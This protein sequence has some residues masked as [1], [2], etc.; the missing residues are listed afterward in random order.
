MF[1]IIIPTYNR[2]AFISKAID[3]VLSQRYSNWELIV[4][5]DASTDNTSELLLHYID[6]RIHVITNEINKERSASRNRGIALAKGEYIC[7]LDSDDYFLPQHLESIALSIEQ[8]NNKVALFYTGVQKY[9]I[10]K[11]TYEILARI[12]FNN[13]VETVIGCNILPSSVAIHYSI[14]K[15]FQFDE[16][17]HINEDVYLF[18]LI[19][20]SYP[21]VY[22]SDLSVVWV[23][24]GNNTIDQQSECF[25]P[26][27]IALQ[28][29]TQHPV[30]SPH[31]TTP[32]VRDW[33]FDL[34][35]SLIYFHAS[36][37][38]HLM[39][40]SFLMKGVFTSPFNKRNWTN[41]LNVI[42]HLPG[43]HLFKKLVLTV[44]H[45]L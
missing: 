26:Q 40:M 38:N 23:L 13:P 14:L 7:F 3:S 35:S 2:A 25:S 12:K 39:A 16:S 37:R 1:S 43:G 27:L 33:K 30:I 29:I 22:I 4:I 15:Q 17:M 9:Y 20:S 19:A 10:D 34:Y 32:F 11:N 6:P 42:Y 36:H 8:T 41:L 21:L 28:K 18:A 31:L 44:K 24:H 5:D 45:K